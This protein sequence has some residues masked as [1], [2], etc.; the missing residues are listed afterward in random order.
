M[1]LL[2]LEESAAPSAPEAP[3]ADTT[4]AEAST[5]ETAIAEIEA[6]PEETGTR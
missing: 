4:A 2:L 6:P 1:M 3:G 5:E